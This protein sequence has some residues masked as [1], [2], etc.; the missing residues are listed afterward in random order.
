MKIHYESRKE[1]N[2][3]LVSKYVKCCV[4]TLI[5]ANAPTDLRI[6]PWARTLIFGFGLAALFKNA[7]EFGQVLQIREE[8]FPEGERK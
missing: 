1:C 4:S 7:A 5:A 8:H 2:R 6:K 3:D